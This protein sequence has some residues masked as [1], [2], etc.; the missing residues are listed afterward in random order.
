MEENKQSY[1][2]PI[3]R[4][5]SEKDERLIDTGMLHYESSVAGYNE[6]YHRGE[7]SHT[8]HV[9]W[10]R[11]PHSAMR[12]LVFSSL[13]KDK[14]DVATA[15][16]AKLA[17]SCD[18]SIVNEASEMLRS[19]YEA[20]PRVLDMFGGGGT[21]PFE[22]KRLGLDSY[23]IDSNQLS[24]FIQRC[25]MLY[26]DNIDL[27]LAEKIIE[28]IGTEI[29]SNL[30]AR[31]DWLYP[32]RKE[33]NENV[34][35]YVWTYRITCPH[36]GY[37]SILSKRPWLSKKKNR[38][39]GF[40]LEISEIDGT[41]TLRVKD[42]SDGEEPF[43]SHWE[44]Y[45]GVLHCP[46]CKKLIEKV[47]VLDCEGVMT[48]LIKNREGAGKDFVGVDGKNAIPSAEEIRIA[49]E[50]MLKK[51][52]IS[53]P[54]SELPVWSGIV[55]PALYGITIH[56]DFLNKRQRLVLLYL[57]DEL[58]THYAEIAKKDSDMAKFVIGALSSLID[59][60][61]DWNSRLS[62]WIPQN[63]QVGRGFCG[64]GIAMLFDY[65]ETDQTLNGPANLWDKLKRICKGVKSF[66]NC[67]G[68]ITIKHAHAQQLPFD[69]DFFD[70]I[71]TDPPYYDNIYYSI[72]ADFFYAWKK[73]LLQ[74]IEPELLSTDITDCH[75]ELVASSRRVEEGQSAHEEYCKQLNMAF[76]EAARVLK[77][78][79]VFS[80]VYS[81]SSVNGWESVIRAYRQSE[82]MVSSVQPLSIER[83]GRPRA[84]LSQAV[85]TCVA[86]VARKSHDVKQP[87]TMDE[88]LRKTQEYIDSFGRQLIETSGWTQPDAGLAV[89]ACVVGLLANASE[90]KRSIS[91]TDALLAVAKI[92]KKEFPEFSI[93][94]R[95]SL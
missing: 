4:D 42:L 14:S 84:V 2:S 24:V 72:L 1:R 93:K 8:I 15:T 94:I 91:D 6:R 11:R 27:K 45:T 12:S 53:L 35:G 80:F 62:M 71:V 81:H 65:A 73:P 28:K 68:S 25:N 9:W 26:A 3:I 92:V 55:N 36:C 33:T 95:D 89:V 82:F 13:C 54:T 74:K 70:A 39:V 19:Q 50:Q 18:D 20:T 38:R 7:T 83:K 10:A 49:E 32:L 58:A 16:M 34:F 57:I 59:Q 52:D 69:S 30:I 61:V 48:A 23:S 51:L 88:V 76:S 40:V 79:G 41:E 90:I 78:D 47:N 21:I 17:M 46:E 5:V 64:P 56:A 85:N 31:T 43:S 22:A 60:V 87:V 44:R 37:R 86:I 29:L 66:E 67:K 77:K 63:E 75:Y